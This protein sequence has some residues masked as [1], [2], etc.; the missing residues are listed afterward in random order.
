MWHFLVESCSVNVSTEAGISIR[1]Y[2][3]TYNY[4]PALC[5]VH[6]YLMHSVLANSSRRC[7][8]VSLCVRH[9][10]VQHLS[11]RTFELVHA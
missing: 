4:F 11:T 2:V 6:I 8:K 5:H 9:V 7:Y 1:I 10:T 3:L